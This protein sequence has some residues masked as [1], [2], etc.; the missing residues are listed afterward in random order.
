MD[1]KVQIS[2]SGA[3]APE[4]YADAECPNAKR[5]CTRTCAC[6]G[7]QDFTEP[8]ESPLTSGLLVAPTM[9]TRRSAADGSQPSI[10]ISSSVFSRR[11]ASCSPEQ[12]GYALV[13]S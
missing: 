5:Q 10:W 13:I 6:A 9:S 8:L 12:G 4:A 11:L 1:S 7:S 2:V 3:A